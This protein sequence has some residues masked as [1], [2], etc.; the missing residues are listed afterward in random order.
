LDLFE[1]SREI[2]MDV[3]K[4]SGKR[5][6]ESKPWEEKHRKE[7][8]IEAM[9]IEDRWKKMVAEA[10]PKSFIE[11]SPKSGK[12]LFELNSRFLTRE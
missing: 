8:L 7:Y 2:G 1:T 12:P 5:W 4:A 6:L 11:L 3:L 10:K 9:S